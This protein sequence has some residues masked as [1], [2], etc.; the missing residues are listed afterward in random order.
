MT[1]YDGKLL[2]KRSLPFGGDAGADYTNK[3][4][5]YPKGGKCPKGQRPCGNKVSKFYQVCIGINEKCPVNG[6]EIVAKSSLTAEQ[7]KHMITPDNKA[8]NL[9]APQ[10]VL[11][12]FDP[13]NSSDDAGTSTDD[14]LS[15]G[16][17]Q[18]LEYNDTH[19]MKV[20][21]TSTGPMLVSLYANENRPCVNMDDYQLASSSYEVGRRPT[22]VLE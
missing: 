11:P 10:L 20:T 16:H 8:G 18:I 19:A 9:V 5:K 3:K 22:F 17:W 13:Q 2:C 4:L 14:D 12:S 7:G 21:T 6:I 1:I 15:D